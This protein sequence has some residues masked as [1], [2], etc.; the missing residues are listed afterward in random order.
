MKDINDNEKDDKKY[1]DV[2]RPPGIVKIK[3]VRYNDDKTNTN[4]LET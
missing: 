3:N 4:H 2:Y 1:Q